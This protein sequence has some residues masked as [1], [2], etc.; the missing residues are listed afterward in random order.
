M[1]ASYV[2]LSMLESVNVCVCLCEFSS[3][4]L[5]VIR[6]GMEDK[7]KRTI[8]R[9]REYIRLLQRGSESE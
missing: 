6:K 8:E 9:V 2:S 1:Q 4:A 5:V 7:L 3:G